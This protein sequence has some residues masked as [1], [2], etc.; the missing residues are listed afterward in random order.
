GNNI[1]IDATGTNTISGNFT[2]NNA[3][4]GIHLANADGSTISGNTSNNNLGDGIVVGAPIMKGCTISGNTTNNNLGVGLHALSSSN[5]NTITKN[6]SFGNSSGDFEDDSSGMNTAGTAN[7]WS[8]NTGDNR[9]PNG[10]L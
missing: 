4:P 1:G 7:I 3:G 6:K 10:L 8:L 5:G 2:N 9:F